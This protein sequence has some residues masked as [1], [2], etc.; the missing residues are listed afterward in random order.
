MSVPT[1]RERLW[2]AWGMDWCWFKC[3]KGKKLGCLSSNY[4]EKRATDQPARSDD[5]TSD[6]CTPLDCR[7]VRALWQLSHPGP[8][9]T[10][11]PARCLSEHEPCCY[12]KNTLWRYPCSRRENDRAKDVRQGYQQC[13]NPKCLR[14]MW[15]AFSCWATGTPQQS[16][17]NK[18]CKLIN[19]WK[20]Q[21]DCICWEMLS[22]LRGDQSVSI[23]IFSRGHL[24]HPPDR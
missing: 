15:C 1:E 20:T 4:G 6:L 2:W 13:L 10:S 22:R 14:N 11:E 8:S 19:H 18:H 7:R 23:A 16:Y 17:L 21:R 12:I 24:L 5:L 9:L 3:R